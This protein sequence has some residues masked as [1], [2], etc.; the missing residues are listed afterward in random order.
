M[1]NGAYRRAMKAKKDKKLR[2]IINEH[3]GYAPHIGYIDWDYVNGVWQPVG[4][5]VKYPKNSAKQKFLKRQTNKKIRKLDISHKGNDYR[6]HY[7]YWWTM[8]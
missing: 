8:Y 5:Y 4:K 7:E 2:K 1:R 3:T 6:K